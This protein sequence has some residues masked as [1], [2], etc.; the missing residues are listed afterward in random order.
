MRDGVVAAVAAVSFLALPA[1]AREIHELWNFGDPAASERTFRD[2]LKHAQGDVRL[3]LLTQVAR[4]YSLRGRFDDAHRL[5]DEIEPQ[6]KD[7]GRAPR[8][9][10]LLERGRTFRSSGAPDRARPLFIEAWQLARSSG[11][12]GLAVDAAHMVALV[13]T[14]T[15]DQLEWNRRALALAEQSTQPY[16]QGWKASLYNNIGWSLHEAGRYD[17]A[18]AQFEAALRERQRRRQVTEIRFARW[19]VARCL[20]SL[21]RYDEALAI[22]RALEAEFAASNETDGYV[23]EELAELLDATGKPG[24]AKAYFAR[25]A[26]ELGKDDWF[27]KNERARLQRLRAK[28][29]ER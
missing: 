16:A 25:A 15:A 27:V 1:Q 9:R 28:A 29:G 24:E 6:L 4:T 5:L 13:E 11:L 12:D 10:L 26:A 19:A 17:E 14:K 3:E 21:Q 2:E 20:R 22:Q 7:A 8:V 18:L 23:F